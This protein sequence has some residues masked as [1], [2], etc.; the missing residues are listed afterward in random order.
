MNSSVYIHIQSDGGIFL[1]TQDMRA[2]YVSKEKLIRELRSLKANR[3]HIKYSREGADS[4]PPA[5]INEIFS[6]IESFQI[7]IQFV[8]PIP[9][10]MKVPE[11]YVPPI[12]HASYHGDISWLKELIDWKVDLESRD[13][14]GQTALMMAADAGQL[15][16]VKLLIEAGANVN[17]NDPDGSTPLMFAAQHGHVDV[18]RAIIRGGGNPQAKGSHGHDAR[19]LAEQNHHESLVALLQS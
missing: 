13:R 18:A 1:L 2:S 16:A 17:A 8:E 4:D 10:V 12:I 7:P 19:S 6:S 11:N 9:E 15:R 5:H 14:F 3:G